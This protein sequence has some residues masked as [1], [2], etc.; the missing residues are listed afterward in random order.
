[1]SKN[2]DCIIGVYKITNIETGKYYIGYSQDIHKRFK[3][4]I[5]TLKSN[6]HQNIT[7]SI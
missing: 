6:K 7:T 4:H 1:M 3:Q 5:D 2:Q